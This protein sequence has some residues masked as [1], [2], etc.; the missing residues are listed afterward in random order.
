MQLLNALSHISN[1]PGEH[2]L[3]YAAHVRVNQEKTVAAALAA[4]ELT[5]WVPVYRSSRN[6]SDRVRE[7][8]MPLFPGYVF[9][10]IAPEKRAPV[11]MTP[12]VVRIVGSGRMPIPIDDSEME[13]LQQLAESDLPRQPHPVPA[14]GETVEIRG[15]PLAGVV[16]VLEQVKDSRKLIVTISL[17]KR[18]VAVE[19]DEDWVAVAAKQPAAR[20]AVADPLRPA[21]Y[22]RTGL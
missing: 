11:Q 10:R 16:G 9:C 2:L 3:W 13:M 19:F 5:A 20:Y 12:G 6:W 18:S 15:G 7:L 14:L 1:P 8:E 22:K 17:L 21:A 4:R